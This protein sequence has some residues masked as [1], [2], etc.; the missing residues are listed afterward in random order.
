MEEKSLSYLM[1]QD[2]GWH[3]EVPQVPRKKVPH[4]AVLTFRIEVRQLGKDN[5]LGETVL[6]KNE[7]YKYGMSDKAKIHIKGET[8]ADCIRKVKNMLENL[9]VGSRK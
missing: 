5:V 9:D 4:C 8:E 3:Q 2:M 6:S 1:E 7:L